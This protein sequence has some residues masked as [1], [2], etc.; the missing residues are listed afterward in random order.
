MFWEEFQPL[1]PI[2]IESSA[3]LNKGKVPTRHKAIWTTQKTQIFVITLHREEQ[4]FLVGAFL[5]L[6]A[7]LTLDSAIHGTLN[8]VAAVQHNKLKKNS[9]QK[10]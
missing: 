9:V 1:K 8:L 10:N 5:P 6:G 2:V 3:I 7:V 4:N